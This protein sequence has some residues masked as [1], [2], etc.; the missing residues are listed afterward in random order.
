ML[1]DYEFLFLFIGT[2]RVFQIDVQGPQ[3]VHKVV[4]KSLKK[5]IFSIVKK[6]QK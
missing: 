5:N 3:K 1:S 4:Q 6:K 2:I